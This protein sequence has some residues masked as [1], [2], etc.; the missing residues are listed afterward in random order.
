MGSKRT[1][2]LTII[3][4]SVMAWHSVAFAARVSDIARTKHN[5][6]A[7]PEFTGN[8]ANR[9]PGE[10]TTRVLRATTEPQIC[11]FC[12]TPHAA[13][14]TQ[15]PLWNR[16]LNEGTYD[17]YSSSS[18]DAITQT[19]GTLDQPNGVSKLC[20]SCHDGTMAIGAVNVLNGTLTDQNPLTE[21]IA[22]TA[23][24]PSQSPNGRMPVGAGVTTGFTR[25][26]GTDLT[27]DHPIS[28]LY[29]DDLA[30]R[31]G[32]MRMP[33]QTPNIVVRGVDPVRPKI[34]DIQLEPPPT[35]TVGQTGGLVQCNSCHDPHII[36]DTENYNIKFLRLNRLQK[37]PAPQADGATFNPDTDIIC[38]ACHDKAGWANSAHANEQVADEIYQAGAAAVREFPPRTQVWESACLACHDT[39]T[40]EGSRRLLREGTDDVSVPTAESSGY[41]IKPG[42]GRFAIEETCYACHSGSL[43]NRK[44]LQSVDGK[45]QGDLTFPVPD[46]H[47]DFATVG[48]TH[49]PITTDDQ[50][51]LIEVHDIGT[52]NADAES[53]KPGE[54]GKDFIESPIL[55][56]GGQFGSAADI[57]N[58]H[59]ECTDCHNVHRVIKNRRF[60][61]NPSVPDPAGTHDHIAPHTNIA[62]GVLRGIWGVEPV[63]NGGS[64]DPNGPDDP[65][66]GSNLGNAFSNSK[67]NLPASFSVKR[68]NPAVGAST[69]VS[70]TY[71]TREYQ[72]C[73]KCHSNYAYGITP[74]ALDSFTGGTAGGTN[75]MSTYT[76]QAMEFYSP[77]SHRGEVTREDSGART[78]LSGQMTVNNHRSWHPVMNRTGRTPGVRSADENN[79]IAPF[80]GANDVG[81]QTMYCT[82]CHGNNTAEG[83]A[84]PNNGEDGEPWGP[85]GSSNRFLLKGEWS[86]NGPSNNDDGTGRPGTGAG[87]RSHLC[88]KCHEYDQYATP[89]GSQA[90]GFSRGGGMGGGGGGGGMSGNLH[91]FHNRVV[92]NFRCNLC[93]VAVPHGWK[94]KVFLVNLNDV[95]IESRAVPIR[96]GEVRTARDDGTVTEFVGGMGGGGQVVPPYFD[97]PYYNRAALKV[98]NFAVSGQWQPNNCGSI[99]ENG[100]NNDIGVR[101]M[102]GNMGGGGGGGGVSEACNNLP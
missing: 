14:T 45:F 55:M 34:T 64:N 56:G 95:G 68:G 27:N 48:N 18:L 57:L 9:A 73:L 33:S 86:G 43:A 72:V 91:S 49:M 8:L 63:Y 59:A 52:P 25:F 80:N 19:P 6:S 76:N 58:R 61:A 11:V 74:P 69:A 67:T 96:R 53:T 47:T 42:G 62:S 79:W 77:N 60:N 92:S 98:V 44:T 41:P 78:D 93:H 101:W 65:S 75:S 38:L 88:F 99:G 2:A 16:K 10:S 31:D 85:H 13:E 1:L 90:S 94:N 15:G 17:T 50:A 82:D 4:T 40:V 54:L 84:V 29:D 30:L 12:H 102:R 5:F 36:D 3:I 83:T 26:L 70:S 23:T 22:M 21:D 20:L 100:G 7:E 46:V 51:G 66:A 71:V 28:V 32:D 37:A 89:T 87:Q 24:P 39:H 97:G 81:N 35:G